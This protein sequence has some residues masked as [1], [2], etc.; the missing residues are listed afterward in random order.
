MPTRLVIMST[1]LTPAYRRVMAFASPIVK[2]WG[3]LETT[4]VELL[5]GPGPVL[6]VGNH[7]SYWDPVV[8]GVAGKEH[9]QIRAL[10]KDSLWKNKLVA[11]VVTGMAQIP[12]KRGAGDA[13]ALAVAI[14]ELADGSCIGIFPEGTI[15]RGAYLRPRSGAGRLAE[16]VPECRVVLGAITGSVDIV[17]F[18]KRPKIRIDFFEPEGGQKRPDETPAEFATR[19]TEEI[20]RRAPYVVPGRKKTAKKYRERIAAGLPPKAGKGE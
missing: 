1:T 19:V 4:G 6:A 12:V 7:D 11:K 9:R 20:R 17:R 2:T 10:A 14:R 5:D 13:E 18:P 16:A 8:F 3:R 15:S